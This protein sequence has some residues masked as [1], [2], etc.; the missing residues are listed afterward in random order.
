[1]A[2]SDQRSQELT[3][4]K[5]IADY[6][7]ITV[8]TAQKWEKTRGLPVNRTAGTR[9]R[10][11]A[12]TGELDAWK[13]V[14]TRQPPLW[15]RVRPLQWYALIATLLLLAT[16]A[17]ELRRLRQWK[18]IGNPALYNVIRDTLIITDIDGREL[19]R[20]RFGH[21][22]ETS[23]FEGPGNK[24]YVQFADLDGDGG[25]ETLAVDHPE[26]MGLYTTPLICFS[27]SGEEKWR[28]LPGRAVSTARQNFPQSSA[29]V[30]VEFVVFD[31]DDGQKRILVNSNIVGQYPAQIALLTP[32][33]ELEREYWHSG[34]FAR[35][36]VTDLDGNGEKE[37]YLGGVSN[38]YR[39]ATVVA[40]DPRSFEGASSEENPDYQLIG[41]PPPKEL[42]R[43]LLPRSCMSHRFEQY[44][45]VTDVLQGESILTV[46]VYDVWYEGQAY[47][48][49]FY[50]KFG[51]EVDHVDLS[52]GLRGLH[53]TLFARGEIDHELTP[54]EEAGMRN[55]RVLTPYYSDGVPAGTVHEP[56][57]GK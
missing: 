3:S 2:N 25:V 22:L 36:I 47:H 6:L 10:I 29:Y 5:E 53:H 21:S 14:A 31:L 55:I 41:F 51:L 56:A 45:R 12:L 40:L 16:G 4:W 1:L 20:K 17:D 23:V 34:G 48:V 24:H 13:L 33:G 54:E 57:S 26:R 43:I 8:R 52:D 27:E 37:I 7:G 18:A 9:G 15:A 28:F 38:G 49:V 42:G 35:V 46:F 50:L 19:W 30:I 44:N 32:E 39:Q 11:S